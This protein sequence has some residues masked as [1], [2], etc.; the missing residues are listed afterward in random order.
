MTDTYQ[1][2]DRDLGVVEYRTAGNAPT[3]TIYGPDVH[4]S[5]TRDGYIRLS[6]GVLNSSAEA[7]EFAS[8]LVAAR[9][10][11]R[12]LNGNAAAL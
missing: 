2:S 7:D 10:E 9:H 4:F 12:E 3:V 8:I 1:R 6:S 11:L 5:E